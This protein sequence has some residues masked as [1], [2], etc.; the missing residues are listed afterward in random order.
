MGRRLTTQEKKAKGTF[1]V[2]S[3]TERDFKIVDGLVL[4][5]PQPPPNFTPPQVEMWNRYWRH[6]IKHEYGKES[7]RELV[8]ATVF[9]WFNYLKYREFDHTAKLAQTALANYKSMMD[10]LAISP[11]SMGKVAVLQ[12]NNKKKDLSDLLKPKNAVNV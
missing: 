11:N 5:T 10:A 1:N 7:D 4:M 2:T 3:D 6:L 12:K 9:E 8:E